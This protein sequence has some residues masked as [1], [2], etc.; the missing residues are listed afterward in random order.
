VHKPAAQKPQLLLATCWLLKLKSV[1][2][3]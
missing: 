2:S 3:M 1:E